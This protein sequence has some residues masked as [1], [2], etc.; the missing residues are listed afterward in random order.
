MA[1]IVE[2]LIV[3]DGFSGPMR[4]FLEYTEEADRGMAG[5]TQRSRQAGNAMVEFAADGNRSTNRLL[6]GIRNLAAGYLG[7]QGVLNTLNL[8]DTFAQT[9]ARLDLMNDGLQTTG[10]LTEMI[11][12]SAQRSRGSFTETAALVAKLGTLAGDAFSSSG[13][14][15]AFAEQLNKQLTISGAGKWE[16]EAALFQL[17]QGLASGTLRGEELNSVLEQA[18]MIAQTIADYMGV[19]IGEMRDLASEG[20]VTADIVK[21]AMF[22]A[23]DET[24]AKFE[25]MP[26]TW[27]QVWTSFANTAI[28]ASRPI[29]SVLSWIANNIAIIAPLVLGAGAAFA[30]FQ[31]AANSVKIA[32]AVTAGYRFVIELLRFS[33][34][35][36]T[37]QTY[38]A[39]AA[40]SAFMGTLAANPITWVVMGIMLLIGALYAGVAAWNYFTG[41]SVSATGIIVGIIF[42]A[43]AFVFNFLIGIYNAMIQAVWSIFVEPFLDIVEFV[44]NAANGGFTNFGN[45]VENLIGQII[46][47]FLNLGKVV[48]QIIDAIFGTNW[49]AGLSSLQDEL[50]SRG[51]ND[52][53]ITIERTVPTIE[54]RFNYGD[55]WNKGY[56]IG[57]NFNPFDYGSKYGE[58]DYSSLAGDAVGTLG[59]IEDDTKSI[60]K[61]VDMSQEDLKSFID[62]ATRKYVNNINLTAQTPV[63]TINGANTGNTEADRKALGDTIRDLLLEQAAAASVRTTA[64]TF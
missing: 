33:L 46:S 57:S 28:M 11:Y 42:S 26:M 47:W 41:A 35:T 18:P 14:I 62:L 13:E 31:V 36:F 2:E 3:R 53:A 59:D 8:S 44:L 17:T 27:A 64:R 24:N 38:I 37:K 16:G 40:T 61:S 12:A 4:L 1:R 50:V 32:T 9:T 52:K 22:A 29:L 25:K 7:L 5:V 48:T 21:N 34:A 39:T 30:V 19:S 10:E 51:K 15:V 56:N 6:S 49:T 54:H 45:A 23:A 60:K 55:S 63:I 58:A 43:G 20:M